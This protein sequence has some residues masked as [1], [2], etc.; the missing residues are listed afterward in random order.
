VV[1]ACQMREKRGHQHRGSAYSAVGSA[2]ERR[3]SEEDRALALPP[4][5]YNAGR[6]WIEKRR[7]PEGILRIVWSGAVG[8]T[9]RKVSISP[10]VLAAVAGLGGAGR[11]AEHLAHVS[12]RVDRS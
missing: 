5:Q 12:E 2:A 10:D 11:Q 9:R 8:R 1:A 3:G 6:P 7:V 4:K